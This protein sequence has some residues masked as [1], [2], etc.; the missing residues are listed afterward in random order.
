MNESYIWMKNYAWMAEGV[1]ARAP[2]KLVSPTSATNMFNASGTPTAYAREVWYLMQM[3]YK[4]VG[5]LIFGLL[6]EYEKHTAN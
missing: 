1:A 5:G 3:G 6:M 2:F 4:K